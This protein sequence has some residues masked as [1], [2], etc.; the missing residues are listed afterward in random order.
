MEKLKRQCTELFKEGKF[1]VSK[2]PYADPSVMVRKSDSSI[3]VCIDCRAINQRTV[4]D[5]FPIPRIDDLIEKL[6]EANCIS[7]LRTLI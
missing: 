4:K 6:R 5:S 3:R 2:S 1:R 7:V